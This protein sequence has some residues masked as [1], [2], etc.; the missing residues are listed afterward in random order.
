MGESGHARNPRHPSREAVVA[1]LSDLVA[2]DSVNPSL[3]PGSRGESEIA[4]Y[5]ARWLAE[6]GLA[7]ETPEVAPSRPNAI[8]RLRRGSGRSII[9]NAHLD[10][11]GVAGME[12]PFEPRVDGDRLYGRGAFDMK[13]GWPR[14]CWPPRSWRAAMPTTSI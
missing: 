14:S 9:L 8:G 11:V 10:T 5:V 12:R 2:I 6:R 7:V 4:E 3:V 1:L 13:G